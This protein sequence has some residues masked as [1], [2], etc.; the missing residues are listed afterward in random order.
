M[1]IK[2]YL[3]FVGLMFV[4]YGLYCLVAPGALA[5]A[6][7]VVGSTTTGTTELRAMYGGLQVGAGLL[8]TLALFRAS[9]VRPAVVSLAFL[10]LGLF[11]AR[12]LG[13]LLDGGIT[14]YTVFALV[15][16]SCSGALAAWLATQ[17][18]PA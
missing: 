1:L 5:E 15:F 11:T 17:Q 9:L 3:G 2:I 8:A 14:G 12:T 6:A 4:G 18:S 13:V 16:E 7:G 10:L